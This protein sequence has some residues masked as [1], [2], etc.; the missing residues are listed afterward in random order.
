MNYL[1]HIH[2]AHITD[3]SM[4][5][6]F[7]GDFVKGSD[8]SHLNN[9]HQLGVRLH[10]KIDG[11]TDGHAQVKA[12]RGLFPKSI[13]RM[14][15]VVI[16]IYF[17]HLLCANWARFNDRDL[18]KLLAHFYAEIEQYSDNI[19]DRFEQVRHGLL[20]YRWLSDYQHAESCERSFL[21]IEKRLSNRVIFAHQA[22][23]FIQQN[24]HELHT[25]FLSFYPDL[26]AFSHAKVEA[27]KIQL[28]V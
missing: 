26:I 9:E 10:R 21:H 24:E 11:F 14:S 23:Q 15:G 3:T 18:D 6:N 27:L 20:R 4:L 19:S 22:T 2:L 12:L 5:G 16:D 25:G 13:R 1:A 8:L 17:D 28:S 7:F